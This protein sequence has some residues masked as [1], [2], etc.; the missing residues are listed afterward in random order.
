MKSLCKTLLFSLPL[1]ACGGGSGSAGN[2]PVGQGPDTD[3]SKLSQ[4][5][6]EPGPLRQA[7]ASEL[8]A[9]I[10]NGLRVSLRD[11]QS[12]G[13]M[14][15]ETAVINTT[16]TNKAGGNFSGT[17][18]QV[19]GVDEADSVKYDGKYIYL[20]TPTDFSDGNPKTALKI[21][22]TDP[23]T[24]S[25]TEVSATPLDTKHWGNVSELYLVDGAQGTTGLATIRRSW[26]FIAFTNK[27]VNDVSTDGKPL[28]VDEADKAI[29]ASIWP[30]QMDNG[31]DITLYDVRTPTAPA[32]T[33]SLA[34]DGDLLGTRKIGNTLYVISS[35][36][37]SIPSLNYAAD[38]DAAKIANE[39]LIAQTRVEKLLPEYSVNGGTPQPLAGSN[40]CM[41]PAN[42][43]KADGSLTLI[44]ITAINL[45]SQQLLESVCVNGNVEGIYSSTENLYLGGSD[46]NR[47]ENWQSYTVVHQFAL[48]NGGVDYTATGS[49][50]G[51]L[52]WSSPAFRM[53][54]YQGHLRIIT[55]NY[56]ATGEPT[57]Q[58]QIL[59]KVSGRSELEVVAQLPNK[60]RPD[61][62][63]KPR[64]DIFGVRFNGNSAYV[65]TF[66]RKDPLYV[67]DL[68]TPT[69]PKIAG[70]LEIPGFST[71]LHPVGDHYLFALGNETSDEGFTK[72]VKVSLYDIRDPAN[73]AE[74]SKHVFGTAYSWS[75]ALY[76]H[77][78]LSFL[79][80]NN[81]QLRITLPI[82]LYEEV[83]LPDYLSSRWLSE[84]LYQFEVNGLA[85]GKVSL[86]YTGTVIGENNSQ[87]EYPSS[88][89][90]N[91]RSFLHDDALFYV[92][93]ARVIASPW[94]VIKP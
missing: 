55:S 34:L 40:G 35:F 3:Y 80:A 21:F 10:K 83:K 69:D 43:D 42:I 89:A 52:G 25:V 64:E 47:W 74:I 91:D 84:G 94:Q 77:R 23:A 51:V 53:D 15:R 79:Q 7:S 9:L 85:T 54:E 82:S 16:D 67:L 56:N 46:Y 31:I 90:G 73:P 20:A 17:N 93:G 19:A 71:Y 78:A 57:H 92:Y 32:K 24:A 44:N 59:K 72:G 81:D 61:P 27:V 45:A 30:Y 49:V 70:Q 37:P 18:V 6:I 76:D 60:T 88:Y 50:E 48:A 29:N 75:N 1:V 4:A 14:I 65:V 11:N 26:D 33:W 86:D 12:Y 41:V 22:A 38:T 5:K 8:S 36:V 62:I 63:G 68:A 39:A 87:Q 2:P 13:M 28:A 66:E 58:L